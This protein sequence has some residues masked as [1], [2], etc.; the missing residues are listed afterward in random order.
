MPK[1]KM[2]ERNTSD[3]NTSNLDTPESTPAAEPIES[4]PAKSFKDIFSEYEQ[5]HSRKSEAGNQRR[6]GTVIAVT[7]DFI[8]L[9]IGFKTEGVL[10]LT[11]FPADKPPKAGDKV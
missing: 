6:E 9:D 1:P 4:S 3:P 7:A 11:A 10:P 2:S 8:I 5:S